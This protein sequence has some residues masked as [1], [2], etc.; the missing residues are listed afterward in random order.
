MPSTPAFVVNGRDL[1]NSTAAGS[2]DGVRQVINFLV[3]QERMR[4]KMP[5]PAPR[6]AA[7]P[8]NP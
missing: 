2:W 5:A 8:S 6:S 1:V 7:K 3:M 4:L